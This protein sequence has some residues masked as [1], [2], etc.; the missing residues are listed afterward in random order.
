M[1]IYDSFFEEDFIAVQG[2]ND[3]ALSVLQIKKNGENPLL[4]NVYKALEKLSANPDINKKRSI[5]KS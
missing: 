3:H 2:S 4:R 1:H 5:F